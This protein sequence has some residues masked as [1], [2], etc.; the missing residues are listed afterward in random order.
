MILRVKRS[1]S[2]VRS[3]VDLQPDLVPARQVDHAGRV[4]EVGV[5]P[6]SDEI[7]QTAVAGPVEGVEDLADDADRESVSHAE[8]L[9]QV[10]VDRT[11]GEAP[12]LLRIDRAVERARP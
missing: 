1:S 4:A 11:V 6:G 5:S 9:L 7:V 3:E 12:G 8:V 10:E 2:P